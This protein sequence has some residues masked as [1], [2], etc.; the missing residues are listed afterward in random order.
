M[1][2]QLGDRGIVRQRLVE[3]EALAH[4]ADVVPRTTLGGERGRQRIQRQPELDQV[5]GL[6]EGQ[7]RDPGVPMRVELHQ[8]LTHEAPQRFAQRGGADADRLGEHALLQDRAGCERSGEDPLAQT[9]VGEVALGRVRP[10]LVVRPLASVMLVTQPLEPTGWR[11]D[12]AQAGDSLPDL[13]DG[14]SYLG[15][16]APQYSPLT[17]IGYNL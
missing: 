8:P 11:A 4:V 15:P 7:G 6:L 17:V 16:P 12:Y 3:L 2:C 5:T 9:G 13:A 1:G 10:R 14:S